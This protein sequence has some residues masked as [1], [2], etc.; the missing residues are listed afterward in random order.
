MNSTQD[1]VRSSRKLWMASLQ[2][3]SFRESYGM[4]KILP[5]L[6]LGSLRD[7]NDVEQLDANEISHVVSIHELSGCAN[8]V[9]KDRDVLHIRVADASEANIREHFAETAA[10]IHRARLSKKSVLVHCIAGVSRSVCIVASYLIVAC[11]LGYAAALAYIVSKRPCANPNFGF[12]M[13]LADYAQENA[14]SEAFSLKAQFTSEECDDLK[15]ADKQ[16]LSNYC[17]AS[18]LDKTMVS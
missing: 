2:G 15:E 7:A 3:G 16:F 5:Y 12:R 18:L 10:F 11:D 14:S 13:Q 4:S 9:L 17:T 6:Y 1:E 8:N